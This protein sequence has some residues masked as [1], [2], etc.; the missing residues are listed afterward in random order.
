MNPPTFSRFSMVR[1]IIVL[2]C[3]AGIRLMTWSADAQE[4]SK[5]KPLEMKMR[6]KLS[7]ASKVLEGLAIEDKE[8]VHEG[9]KILTELS[10]AEVWLV[11]KDAEYREHTQ[12]FRNAVR[13]LDEA[14]QESRFASAQLEWLDAN[15]RCFD[16][17]NYMRDTKSKTE[18][19]K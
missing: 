4:E 19:E 12:A 7:A 3:L 9:T 6:E 5:K 11:L 8:L 17:H 15:K 1:L 2:T 10:K 13:R 14:A 16:C 18:K